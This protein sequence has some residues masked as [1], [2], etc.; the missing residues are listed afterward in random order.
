MSYSQGQ[1]IKF[2]ESVEVKFRAFSHLSPNSPSI[3]MIGFYWVLILKRVLLI[4][5]QVNEF[6]KYILKL[7]N[8]LHQKHLWLKEIMEIDL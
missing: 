2:I 6:S 3:K 7:F 1:W 8:T 5:D 4:V